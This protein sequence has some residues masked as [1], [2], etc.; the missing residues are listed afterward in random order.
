[1]VH[2]ADP[3]RRHAKAARCQIASRRDDCFCGRRPITVP[4]FRAT[5]R[6]R[7]LPM[8]ITLICKK[9]PQT[10]RKCNSSPAGRERLSSHEAGFL[11]E[12]EADD[13]GDLVGVANSAHGRFGHH[14]LYR[15]VSQN[16]YHLCL[17]QAG[18]HAIDADIMRR[19]S[20]AAAA[21]Q[22][23]HAGLRRCVVD[24][25]LPRPKRGDRRYQDDPPEPSLDHL[26]FDCEHDQVSTVQVDVDRFEPA[27][28]R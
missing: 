20:L 12:Q 25:H 13:R 5:H 3:R 26:V 1:M 14:A 11:A 19:K 22:G 28:I 18:S 23:N 27:L 6:T 17:D 16:V 10:S 15:L 7:A 4:V 8:R 24:L 2:G 21:G 9:A